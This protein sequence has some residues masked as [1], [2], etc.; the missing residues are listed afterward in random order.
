MNFSINKIK[1]HEAELTVTL[2]KEDLISYI[3]KAEDILVKEYKSDGFRPGK[4]PKDIIRKKIGESV[5]KEEALSLA[6]ESSLS[7][8]IIDSGLSVIDQS[9]FKIKENSPEKLLYS[10]KLVIVPEIKLG[11]YKNLDVKSARVIVTKEEVDA[12]LGEIALSRVTLKD[13]ERPAQQGD[14]VEL[15][16]EVKDGGVLIEG[17]KSENHPVVL[18]ENKFVPGF[19]PEIIGLKKGDQ[20]KFSLKIPADYYQK[21]IAGKSV[22]FDVLVKQVQERI[23]PQVNDELAISL[24]KFGSKEELEQN[25]MQGLVLEKEN[26]EKERVRLLLLK[27]I[28]STSEIKP[29]TL[30]VDR[31]LDGMIQDLDAELHQRGMELGLYLAHVKKTQDDLRRDWK[32]KA[33]EQVRFDLITKFIAQKESL[34]VD[35]DEIEQEAQAALQQY[36]AMMSGQGGGEAG[37]DILKDMD[38]DKLRRRIATALLNEKVL[39]FLEQNNNISKTN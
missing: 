25:I 12:V 34:N 11:D 38:T 7:K 2:N 31:R 32:D 33:E 6:V 1:D 30:L 19:E 16:F 15:D 21:S 26:K 37:Q 18:G 4:V 14:R 36:M 17:G 28:T 9:D 35:E 5:I 29:P 39:N 8:S 24:G 27:Q 22:D 20:K 13:V 23:I 3:K 10:V